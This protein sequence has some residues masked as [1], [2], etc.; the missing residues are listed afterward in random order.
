MEVV[1]LACHVILVTFFVAGSYL[2]LG[3]CQLIQWAPST[4][5]HLQLMMLPPPA[6]STQLVSLQVVL[7]KL[8]HSII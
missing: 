6:K 8:I 1:D 3:G 7:L 4:D 5:L 2:W